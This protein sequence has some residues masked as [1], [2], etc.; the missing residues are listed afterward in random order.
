MKIEFHSQA[1]AEFAAAIRYYESRQPGLG[2]KL[3]REALAKLDWIASNPELPRP[4]SNHRRVNLNVF[5]FFI[6]YLLEQDVIWVVA[7]AHSH[8]RPGYWRERLPPK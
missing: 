6:A 1:D 4:R 8:R 5:P 7:V 2:V 3:Y